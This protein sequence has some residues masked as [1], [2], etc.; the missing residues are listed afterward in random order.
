M[1][2]DFP[3][4]R[5]VAWST[6]AAMVVVVLATAGILWLIYFLGGKEALRLFVYV[7]LPIMVVFGMVYAVI[8]AFSQRDH[9][10]L[11]AVGDILHANST[12]GAKQAQAVT[13]VIKG[14]NQINKADA[15]VQIEML[16]N[17][18]K[19][20]QVYEKRLAELNFQLADQERQ[21]QLANNAQQD[22]SKLLTWDVAEQQED[23]PGW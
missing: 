6:I 17:E 8:I 18:N 15:D 5:G 12:V 20:G 7:A 2:E 1:Y 19:I 22:P 16:R 14:A 9:G 13:E 3:Q 4:Q 10:M 23:L 21:L 11:H